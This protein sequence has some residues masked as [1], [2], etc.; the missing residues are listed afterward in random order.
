MK[1]VRF[2]LPFAFLLFVASS[3][4]AAEEGKSFKGT[5]AEKPA[6]AKAGVVAVLTQRAPRA[7][8]GAAAAEA[9]KYSLVAT[10]EIATQLTDLAAKKAR[11]EVTGVEDP[12]GTI[13][14]SK[15]VE[16]QGRGGGGAPKG[17]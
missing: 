12:A 5:L 8:E 14:V 9:K 1:L 11:V 2:V 10:G 15:V 4:F 6:D 3:V 7:A 16:R 13:K 17:Q